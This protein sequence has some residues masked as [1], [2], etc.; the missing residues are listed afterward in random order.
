VALTTLLGIAA[1]AL[2]G[3]AAEPAS[4]KLSYTQN[5]FTLKDANQR[6]RFTVECPGKSIPFGGGMLTGPPTAD[7]EGAF[8]NSYERLGVQHGYHVTAVLFDQS[9]GD[10]VAHDLTVQVACGKKPGK[11]TPPH[12]T[13]FVSPGETK[14]AVAKCPGRRHLIGG[15]FQRTTLTGAGGDYIT[16]SRAISA[17]AWKVTATGF[18]GFGG[19]LTAIGYCLHSKKPLLTQVS[20]STTVAPGQYGTTTTPPCPS[21]RTLVFG[22]FSGVP[23]GSTLLTNG[24]FDP[25]G[26]WVSS[27][28]N[29]FGTGP[30]TVTAYGYCARV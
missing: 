17:K 25:S 6:T 10:T 24:G 2:L 27:G 15:G 21:G 30:A 20:N 7:G 8:P 16:E 18:G 1:I 11:I 22:G 29:R 5:T 9:P 14:S 13:I 23:D 4:A 3:A 12:Q 28:F 19:E 26:G